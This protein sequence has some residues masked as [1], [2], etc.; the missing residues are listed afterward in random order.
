MEFSSENKN[1]S[2]TFKYNFFTFLVKS[3]L[4]D[5][6]NPQSKITKKVGSIDLEK[7]SNMLTETTENIKEIEAHLQQ[8]KVMLI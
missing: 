1:E 4:W 7:F 5:K 2:K 8:A 3:L 6:S